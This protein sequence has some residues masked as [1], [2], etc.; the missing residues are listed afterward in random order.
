MVH[1]KLDNK[2]TL[3]FIYYKYLNFHIDVSWNRENN[4]FHRHAKETDQVFKITGVCITVILIIYI[5]IYYKKTR[6]FDH[7]YI[8]I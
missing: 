6:L 1:Q 4:Q 8:E 3:Y 5:R 2:S 7:D